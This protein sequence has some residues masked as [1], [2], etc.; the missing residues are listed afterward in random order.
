[1][2]LII[3]S[4]QTDT[5]FPLLVA[6]NRDE[7]F[8]RPTAHADFWPEKELLAGRDLLAGGTWLGITRSGRFAA[9][10]NIR[11]PSQTEQKARSRG[12]LTRQF[13]LGPESPQQYC[14]ALAS[15]FDEYA[16]YNLLIGDRESLF[17]INNM[18]QTSKQLEPGIYGLSNGVLNDSWPKVE[19]GKQAMQGLLDSK[20]SVS[21]D[22]LIAMMNHREQAADADLPDTGVSRKLERSLSSAFIQNPERRYGTLC[23]TAVIFHD[24]GEIRFSEQNYNEAGN[25]TDAHY[26]QLSPA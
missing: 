2:C 25:R 8:S 7:Y 20:N 16:G 1:M 3:F 17:Y 11:D 24:S 26:Y 13:L 19:W 9:V 4:F 22:K 6:A 18:Q 12:E 5:R 10:T 21:T 23:S 15:N 14:E